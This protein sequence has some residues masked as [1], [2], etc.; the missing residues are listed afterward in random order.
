MP[1][2]GP[3]LTR[4]VQIA[5]SSAP[6]LGCSNHFWH[7]STNAPMGCRP[8]VLL[9]A[10][11][12]VTLFSGQMSLGRSRITRARRRSSSCSSRIAARP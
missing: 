1:S 5:S 12:G 2:A 8:S 3:R 6:Y 9:L 10:S 7:S 4:S 11:S